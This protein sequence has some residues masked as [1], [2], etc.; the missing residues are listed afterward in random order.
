MMTENVKRIRKSGLCVG[1]GTCAGI[2]PNEAIKMIVYEDVYLPEI[3]EEKCVSCWLCIKSCPGHFVDF[4]NLNFK[5][6]A[7]Q[8]ENKLLGNY[9]ECYIGYSK[10]IEIRRNSTSGGIATQLLFSALEAG[11]IDGALVVRMKRDKPLETEAFIAR[12]KKTILQASK[13]KYCPVASNEILKQILKEN[14]RF[15]V[16]GLP[17]HIH[18]I[19]KA[20]EVNKKLKERIV[21]T[22]GLMCSH[23]VN[24]KGTKFILEKLGVDKASVKAI[25]YRCSGWPGGMEITLKDGS[26]LSIPLFGTWNSYWSVF[27]SYFFTPLRCLMCPDQTAE[28]ADISLGDAWLPELSFDKIGRSIIVTRTKIAEDIISL[29]RS[30]KAISVMKVNPT[31]VIQTQKL[32]LR[33]KKD[34]FEARCSLLKLFGKSTPEF[35]IQTKSTLLPMAFLKAFYPYFNSVL[36]SKTH[37][38]AVLK[39]VPFPLF[40]LYFGFYKFLSCI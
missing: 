33:F 14:G 32:L 35:G 12:T 36:S 19:R 8:P 29:A 37:V 40:R 31:K 30:S 7:K 23:T 3:N 13:S 34:F 24:Y 26:N 38:I 28:L 16:V 25:G 6:F 5:I 20:I 22:I 10:D 15:A 18:G 4:K 11:I 2:C 21:L 9:L 27:S 1:C 39:Y 17:C